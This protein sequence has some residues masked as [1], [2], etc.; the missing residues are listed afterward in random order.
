MN[1]SLIR[2][3]DALLPQT[4]CGLCGYGGCLP[5]AT[6]IA[7]RGEEINRCPPGGVKTLLA[8]GKL[9]GRDPNP[10]TDAMTVQEK[11]P[12]V[13][14][15][16]ETECIGCTKCIKAC[17]VDAI[18]GAAKQLHSILER[19][20][21]GCGLCI[22]PCPVDCIDLIQ[23]EQLQYD[24]QQARQRFNAKQRRK[25]H[26]GNQENKITTSQETIHD[27]LRDKKTY[28]E[29]AIMRAKKKREWGTQI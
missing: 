6:A 17:P 22:A 16:R 5:Y 23:V 25:E 12:Q 4:Q 29:A 26:S 11:P 18:I 15:I 13:V 8:L 19:E 9:V 20:C 21:T 3:I 28:I 2:D 27:D 1:D 10:F 14:K 7:T 24:P